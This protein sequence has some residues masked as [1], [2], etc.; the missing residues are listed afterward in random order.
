MKIISYNI[1]GI[2]AAIRKDIIKWIKITNPDVIC[3][4]EIK[5][6][7]TQF[8]TSDFESL[9]TIVGTS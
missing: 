9:G 1:N 2:R 6:D 3:L 4:Q 5:A 8:N 7:P